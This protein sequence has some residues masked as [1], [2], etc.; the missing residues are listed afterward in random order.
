MKIGIDL[1]GSH[2]ATGLINENLEIIEKLDENFT[3]DEK[4]NFEEILIEKIVKN[5]N[6]ILEH[7]NILLEQIELI[8]IACPRNN[9]RTEK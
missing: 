9:T 5:I 1:G 2:I 7:N 3:L 8:G 4:E 6:T